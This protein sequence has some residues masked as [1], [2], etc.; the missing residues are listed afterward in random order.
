MD[1]PA[2]L[3]FYSYII[4]R[5]S[6]AFRDSLYKT[7]ILILYYLLSVLASPMT[8]THKKSSFSIYIPYCVNVSFLLFCNPF[9]LYAMPSRKIFKLKRSPVCFKGKKNRALFTKSIESPTGH[10]FPDCP[11]HVSLC[12][13]LKKP[14]R[15]L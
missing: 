11:Y 14:F 5:K 12:W 2:M 4:R 10:T 1:F 7:E 3:S 15:C 9:Y 8:P 6:V 13:S